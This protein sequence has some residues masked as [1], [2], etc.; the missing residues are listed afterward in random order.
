MSESF[1]VAA[2]AIMTGLP[3]LINL[4]Y[5]CQMWTPVSLANGQ[6]T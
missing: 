2:E 5:H 4:R 1:K 6:S 3:L